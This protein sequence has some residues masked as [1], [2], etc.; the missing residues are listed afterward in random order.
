MNKREFLFRCIATYCASAFAGFASWKSF[1]LRKKD[2]SLE[3]LYSIQ[4]PHAMTKAEYQEYK[5]DAIR[6]D[7][8]TALLHRF[9]NEGKILSYKYS[10][11]GDRSESRIRFS[12]IATYSEWMAETA[13]W[14]THNGNSLAQ[15]GLHLTRRIGHS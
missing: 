2:E 1:F 7:E 5:K 15:R 4:L 13:R 6:H 12:S 3:V 11:Q 14:D 10:F 8:W 9:Q